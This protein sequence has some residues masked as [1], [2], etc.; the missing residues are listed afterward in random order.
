MLTFLPGALVSQ[1]TPSQ[2][3]SFII[4]ISVI[5]PKEAMSYAGDVS[6]Q[7]VLS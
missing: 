4:V 2:E 3:G 6:G 1:A 5:P 7:Q